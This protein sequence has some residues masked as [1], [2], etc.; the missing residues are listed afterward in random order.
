MGEGDGRAGAWDKFLAPT[1]TT[2]VDASTTYDL[3]VV[4]E[5]DLATGAGTRLICFI[6]SGFLA[7]SVLNY[8]DR[9]TFCTCASSLVRD[10]FARL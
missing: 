2:L 4:W 8:V 1:L 7:I 10:S 9:V 3:I 6:L 5:Y